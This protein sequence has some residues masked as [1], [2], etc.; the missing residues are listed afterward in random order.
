MGLLGLECPL[1]PPGWRQGLEGCPEPCRGR[2]CKWGRERGRGRGKTA[3]VR[4]RGPRV[5]YSTTVEC[6]RRPRHRVASAPCRSFPAL[7]ISHPHTSTAKLKALC[8][9][10]ATGGGDKHKPVILIHLYTSW[11]LE[12]GTWLIPLYGSIFNHDCEK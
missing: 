4:H 7:S 12:N 5:V 1:E 11:S 2:C 9:R 3:V 6:S 10:L 8:L